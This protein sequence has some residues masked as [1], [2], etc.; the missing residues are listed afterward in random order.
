MI[1]AIFLLLC[2]PFAVYIVKDYINVEFIKIGLY[3]GVIFFIICIF[4]LA[5]AIKY[6]EKLDN[7]TLMFLINQ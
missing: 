4:L 3:A 2:L 6:P 7:V 1:D 5:Y